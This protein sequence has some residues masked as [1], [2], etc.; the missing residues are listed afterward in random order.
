MTV[1]PRFTPKKATWVL[2]LAA[3]RQ[4][5]QRA[6]ISAALNI[7][8][9][10]AHDGAAKKRHYRLARASAIEV[11]AAYELATAIGEKV[12]V[13]KVSVLCREIAAVLTKLVR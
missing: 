3:R 5:S 7:A 9:G 13:E 8:E 11:V 10:A 6:S 4:S 12:C 1:R 2:A